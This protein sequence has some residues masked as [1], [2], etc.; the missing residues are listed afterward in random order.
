MNINVPLV[1]ETAMGFTHAW[2]KSFLMENLDEMQ[3]WYSNLKDD[4]E[5]EEGPCGG[6]NYDYI[7]FKCSFYCN[8][9]S[10]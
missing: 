1:I 8:S 9:A 3:S 7:D 5:V 6:K 2:I 10:I 4:S